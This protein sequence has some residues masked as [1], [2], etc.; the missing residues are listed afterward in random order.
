MKEFLKY[1]KH[2]IIMLLLAIIGS[3][4]IA[5]AGY[6]IVGNEIVNILQDTITSLGNK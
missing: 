2:K 6:Y 4:I 3:V 1:L 5:G